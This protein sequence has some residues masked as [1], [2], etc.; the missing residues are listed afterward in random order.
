MQEYRGLGLVTI[1]AGFDWG[2]PYTCEEWGTELGLSFPIL[3]DTDG[4]LFSQFAFD[5]QAIPQSVLIN[6]EME[7]VYTIPGMVNP[8]S[9]SSLIEETLAECGDNC[10]PDVDGDGVLDY[11]DNCLVLYNPG[12]SDIDED[13]IGDF[14]LGNLNNSFNLDNEPIIDV[15]DLLHLS[16][17]FESD[18]EVH[19]CLLETGDVTGDG[20]V[21][22]IDIFAF[23][24]MLI[25]NG[26]N[27]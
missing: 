24:S 20:I 12:Q 8:S 13:G 15:I 21:N 2:L 26:F 18:D 1:G 7:I 16:D 23:A 22:T 17:I 3:D 6:H 9:F 5:G 27:N 10:I 11:E 14:C 4:G 19:E 25:E